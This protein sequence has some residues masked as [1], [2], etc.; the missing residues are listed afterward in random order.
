MLVNHELLRL[1]VARYDRQC[2]IF[3][4]F[5]FMLIFAVGSAEDLSAKGEEEEEQEQAA[6]VCQQLVRNIFK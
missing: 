3:L 1:C 2:L 6:E 4:S 5:F